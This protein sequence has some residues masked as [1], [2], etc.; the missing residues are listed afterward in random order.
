[1]KNARAQNHISN[2]LILISQT[3]MIFSPLNYGISN[4]PYCDLPVLSRTTAVTPSV[5]RWSI[6]FV[7]EDTQF[8]KMA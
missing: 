3:F 1:M 4:S 6:F 5:A 8:I 7:K 2:V